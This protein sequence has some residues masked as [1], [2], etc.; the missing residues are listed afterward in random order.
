MPT[1]ELLPIESADGLL[2][3]IFPYVPVGYETSLVVTPPEGKTVATARN[4]W[5]DDDLT[6]KLERIGEN[7][8]RLPLKVPGDCELPAIKFAF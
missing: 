2:A 7:K 6:A 5:R 1:M 8:V 3:I 4:L